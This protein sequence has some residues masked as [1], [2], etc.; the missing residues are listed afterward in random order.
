MPTISFWSG[1]SFDQN[2][3]DLDSPGSSI[4]IP[5]LERYFFQKAGSPQKKKKKT[6]R[7]IVFLETLERLQESTKNYKILKISLKSNWNC[8]RDKSLLKSLSV[9]VFNP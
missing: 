9:S 4:L 7:Y 2:L 6:D 1:F 5:G 8:A 3:L